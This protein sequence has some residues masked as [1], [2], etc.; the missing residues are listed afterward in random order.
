MTNYTYVTTYICTYI[1]NYMYT[2][3]MHWCCKVQYHHLVFLGGRMRLGG[4]WTVHT[5]IPRSLL[6][7]QA[8][9]WGQHQSTLKIVGSENGSEA[10]LS[11]GWL[12]G[13]QM[14]P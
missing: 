4:G 5:C 1:L 2:Q 7:R 10:L 12:K 8:I 6:I 14:Q 9:G 3:C 11:P 13:A